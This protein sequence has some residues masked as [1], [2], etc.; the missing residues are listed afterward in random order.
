MT[1]VDYIAQRPLPQRLRI[2]LIVADLASRVAAE[3][4]IPLA[5]ILGRRR[6]APVV[7]ARQRVMLEAREAGLSYPEIGYALGRDHSTVLEGVRCEAKRRGVS[8]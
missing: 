5:A 2:K 6:V 4:G 1:P 7:R 8:A 3:T